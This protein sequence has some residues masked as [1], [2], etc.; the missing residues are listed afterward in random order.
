VSKGLPLLESE[1]SEAISQ[2][3]WPAEKKWLLKAPQMAILSDMEPEAVIKCYGNKRV[4]FCFRDL[5][6]FQK[7]AGFPLF[8]DPKFK[9]YVDF[10]F[11]TRDRHIYLKCLKDCQSDI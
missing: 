10:A 1:F 8:S 11:L 3:R 4:E 7:A 6:I 5:T 9:K 2:N